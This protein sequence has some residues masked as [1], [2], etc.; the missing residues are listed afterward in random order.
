MKIPCIHVHCRRSLSPR[1]RRSPSPLG[2]GGGGGGRRMSPTPMRRASPPRR[3]RWGRPG[4]PMPSENAPCIA[5]CTWMAAATWAA[6]YFIGRLYPHSLFTHFDHHEIFRRPL[7]G[8]RS[9][10]CCPQTRQLNR[11]TTSPRASQTTKLVW[12]PHRVTPEKTALQSTSNPATDP[13]LSG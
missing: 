6:Q 11:S 3:D 2:G 13:Q 5:H 8:C 4:S 12:K 9:T 10:G 7:L 1:R